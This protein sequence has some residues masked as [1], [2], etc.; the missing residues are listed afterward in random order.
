[1]KIVQINLNHCEAAHDLL[2][3]TIKE[4]GIDIVLVSE[5]YKKLNEDIWITDISQKTAIWTC[6][7]MAFQ[8]TNVH[9]TGF[10]TAKINGI[11]FYSCYAPPSWTHT[12]YQ[13]M[14]DELVNDAETK[15]KVV[16][17]GDFNAWALEWGSKR[18]D[19]RGHC[20]LDTFAP[21]Q[22]NLLNDGKQNTFRKAGKGSIIDITFASPSI[23]SVMKWGVS[24]EYTGSDHQAVILELKNRQNQ[25]AQERKL[26]GPKWKDSMF[27]EDAFKELFKSCQLEPGS[28]ETQTTKLRNMIAEACDASMPRRTVST[29]RSPC[30]WWNENV[31]ALRKKCLTARRQVQRSRGRPEFDSKLLIFKNLRKSLRNSIK[32]SKAKCFDRLREEIDNSVWGSAYKIVVKKLVKT[33]Q[34]RCPAMLKNITQTLFPRHPVITVVGVREVNVSEIP[35]ITEL[36]L[37][38]ACKRI[39]DNKTP[40]PDGIPNKALKT[41]I[42][43]RPDMFRHAFQNCLKE[44]MFPNQWKLQNLVLIPKGGK[45][46]NEA[47]SYRPICLLD[48]MGKVLE[49]IIYNRLLP[50]AEQNGA[51]SEY[52]YGF[53]RS[54]ST[55]DAVNTVKTIAAEAIAGTRW[56][57]GTKQY[58]A[59]VTLDIK[60]AFNSANWRF[61][62]RALVKMKTPAYLLE[63]IDSY[64]NNRRLRY[65]SENGIE[66]YDI[67]AGVPQG[68]ILG[69]LLW[70]IMY[71]EVLRLRLPAEVKIIGFADDIA[72]VTVA[73]HIH[74]VEAATNTA[75]EEI[76][77]WLKTASLTLAEHKTEAVLIS[78]RKKIEDMT[79][80]VGH[81]SIKSSPYIKYLG[82]ILDNRL[83]FKEHVNYTNAKA[84]RV[85]TL[86]ARLMPNL[87]GPKPVSRKL[88]SSVI[89]SVMLYASPVWAEAISVTE[90]RRKLIST[91]RRSALRTI[92]GFRT[93]SAEAAFVIGGMIPIDILIDEQRRIYNR[94]SATV[95]SRSRIKREERINSIGIWQSRWD[96]TMKGEWTR[97]LIPNIM[98]WLNRPHGENNFY[99]TQFLTGHGCFRKYLYKFGHDTSPLCPN[100]ENQEEDANHVVFHCPR[101]RNASI[102]GNVH[103]IVERM[104][105]SEENWEEMRVLVTHILL[106]LRRT[107]RL[108]NQAQHAIA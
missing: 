21:L 76:R 100:C 105:Q 101:F 66:F 22:L 89:N 3:Q 14:L 70:N 52:Q 107:E 73:K 42:G 57:E 69:P 96:A 48:T 31:A 56:K 15:T 78:S 87:R 84:A 29:K 83:S 50:L 6:G 38:E 77:A 28:A 60:N 46:P 34:I 86:L 59:V 106:E 41:A 43:V 67:T 99:M 11:D 17:A 102:T 27:D 39:G 74:K 63:I 51:L 75:I 23:S 62:R 24:E 55:I 104:V 65:V 9:H 94:S 44:R 25:S 16:I 18:T 71:D 103:N 72:I 2:Q 90:I 53:R 13:G 93:V 1:M 88:L 49:R 98:E 97:Q 10:V 45:P 5:P 36:E 7:S 68:S 37:S 82:V 32:S 58:C 40:G 33:P 4:K 30:Y 20:L 91:Q 26:N 92:C 95:S 35:V 12:E 64:F 8:E 19:V 108:R 61:V 47:S 54:R 79:I 80:Q 81:K 85:Q